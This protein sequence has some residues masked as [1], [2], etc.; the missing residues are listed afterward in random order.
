MNVSQLA[1]K[2]RGLQLLAAAG[3]AAL[4][5]ALLAPSTGAQ[6]PPP[7]HWLYGQGYHSDNGATVR[8]VS[9]DGSEITRATIANGE[10]SLFPSQ[11]QATSGRVELVSATST[12]TTVAFDV[13]QGTLKNI[14]P[15]EF[16]VVQTPEPAPEPEPEEEEEETET[17]TSTG[18]TAPSTG[19]T[20]TARIVARVS[21]NPGRVGRLEFGMRVEGSDE[22]ITPRA[23]YFPEDLPAD[24][25][26][27]WLR[28]SEID[29]GNGVSGRVI[30][31]QRDDGRIEFAFDATDGGD[32]VP[33][34]RYFP[35]AGSSAYPTHNRW[36]NSPW[37]DIPTD[38]T[39]TRG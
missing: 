28:S 4:L 16:T 17:T 12:R 10:W 32:C 1:I 14:T 9:S 26:D 29:L 7:P 25:I 37:L 36:L 21:D 2:R 11:R 27:R 38:C 33:S 31:R 5:F 24:R 8:F 22:V 20:Q 35:A 18:T 6:T 13:E 15:S 3:L 39:D 19:S 23:R 30:A 34:R